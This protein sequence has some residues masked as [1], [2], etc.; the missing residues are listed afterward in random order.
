MYSRRYGMVRKTLFQQLCNN[1]LFPFN[2]PHLNFTGVSPTPVADRKGDVT[3][4]DSQRRFSRQHSVAML[5][6]CGH[7]SKQCRN[8]IA[9]LCCAKNR[10]CESSR[11]TSP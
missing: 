1:F 3:R 10:L 7:Y 4:D 9:T 2:I 8:N 11:V 5:E 6:Q